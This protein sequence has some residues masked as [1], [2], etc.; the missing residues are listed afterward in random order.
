MTSED[1]QAVLLLCSSLASGNTSDPP[2]PFTLSEWNK[3]ARSIHASPLRRPAALLHTPPDQIAD[4]LGLDRDDANRISNLLSYGTGLALAFDRL[5]SMGIW[6]VSRADDDYPARLRDKLG[7][8]APAL[9]FGAGD[10]TIASQPGIAV[11]GSRDV[12]DSGTQFADTIGRLVADAGFALASGGA[13]GVDSIAMQAALG[14]HGT[15]VAVL[16]HGLERAIRQASYRRAVAAGQLVLLSPF[17]PDAGFSVG[18]AMGRN[19]LI[20]AAAE[21]AVVVASSLGTGGTWNGAIEALKHGWGRVSIWSHDAMPDG[22]RALLDRG[23]DA[24]TDADVRNR[25]SFLTWLESA[26]EAEQDRAGHQLTLL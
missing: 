1:T 2:R 19:R 24:I 25:D 6:A 8:K 16:A 7:A 26:P 15:G 5:T 3:L 13:K 10:I 11:V 4:Q 21:R 12:A 9:L 18:N 14:Q 17:R 22:N 23:A 20:Y